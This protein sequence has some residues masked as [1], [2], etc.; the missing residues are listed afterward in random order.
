M[1]LPRGLSSREGLLRFLAIT[2]ICSCPA[3][4]LDDDVVVDSALDEPQQHQNLIDLG[5]NFDTNL[6]DQKG[7]GWSLQ[8]RLPSSLTPAVESPSLHHGRE[9]G[10][11]QVQQIDSA[12]ALRADQRQRLLLAVESDAQRFAADVDGV[13]EKYAGQN[14]NMNEPAAQKKLHAFQQEMLAYRGRMRN[15]FNGDSL[16]AV[17]LSSILDDRQQA[18]LTAERAAR[19]SFLWR[20][21]VLEVLIAFDD[22][23]GLDEGQHEAIKTVL[24]A[25]EPPL[26]LDDTAVA[27]HDTNLRKNLVLLVLSGVDSKPIKAAVSPRQWLALSVAMNQGKSHRSWVEQRGVLEDKP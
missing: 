17:T 14:L 22:S 16:F 25:N 21:M 8:S 24:L 7:E 9:L 5:A 27:R 3:A 18:C 10:R 15:L 6:F 12:C 4:A 11:K 13:R 23:L 1:Q 20:G 2:L 19:R 26:L